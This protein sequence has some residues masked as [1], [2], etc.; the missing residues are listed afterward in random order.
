MGCLHLEWSLNVVHTWFVF[1]SSGTKYFRCQRL[2][3]QIVI[4]YIDVYAVMV[5]IVSQAYIMNEAVS[6]S[7]CRCSLS[8]LLD[9]LALIGQPV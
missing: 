4:L 1:A 2:R 6:I 5:I 9:D 8:P 3:I 7:S